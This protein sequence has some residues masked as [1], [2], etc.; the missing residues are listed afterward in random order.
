MT[1][2]AFGQQT[3]TQGEAAVSWATWS[4][5]SGGT[6]AV[7]GNADWGKLKL[8]WTNG[9]GRSAVYDMGFVT[10]R[11]FTV[12]N[13]RYGSGS[14]A[15]VLQIRGSESTFTQD[16]TVPVWEEYAGTISRYWRY[17]QVGATTAVMFDQYSG[18]V[19]VE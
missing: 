17:V 2:K 10:S 19:T 3:P 11:T 1:G 13:Q 9:E 18:T 8:P 4:D 5:G 12:T 16:S 15:A 6:P 7:D 14:G